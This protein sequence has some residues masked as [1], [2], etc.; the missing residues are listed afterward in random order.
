[1]LDLH[2]CLWIVFSCGKWGLL[3]DFAHRLL[4]V[5]ATLTG[6]RRLL[7]MW[8]SVV[9]CSSQA[10]SLWGMGLAAP[11]HMGSSWMRDQT[12][13]FCISRQILYHGA[14]RDAPKY[15]FIN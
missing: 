12:L 9:S 2:C 10:Q 7:G 11:R 5:A 13:I 1:M 6:K 8:A 4:I 14:T 15:K 3:F